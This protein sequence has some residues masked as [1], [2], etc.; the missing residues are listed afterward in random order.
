MTDFTDLFDDGEAHD[1]ISIPPTED[2]GITVRQLRLVFGHIC[3][4]CPT[5]G[6]QN[7]DGEVLPPERVSLYETNSKVIMPATATRRCSFVEFIAKQDQ[8]PL[9][10]VSHWWGEP[11]RDFLR[12]LERHI[13]DRLLSD[14]A[15]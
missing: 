6:W 11:V 14:L 1:G 4:R 5:E 10:F 9:W 13:K 7:R 12:C 3:R 8:L 2:R 15:P